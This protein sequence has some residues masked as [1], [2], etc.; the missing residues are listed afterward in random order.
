MP[1]LLIGT[2]TIFG[3][4]QELSW[5]LDR[6]DASLNTDE[7]KDK[8]LGSSSR[9]SPQFFATQG[10]IRKSPAEESIFVAQMKL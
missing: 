10:R 7:Q 3:S 5:N 8:D 9:Q 4:T 1:S 2:I 6:D